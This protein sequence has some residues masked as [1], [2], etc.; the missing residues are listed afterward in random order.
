MQ[1]IS[2][3][4]ASLIIKTVAKLIVRGPEMEPPPPPQGNLRDI[5]VNVAYTIQR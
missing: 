2:S 1:Y 5:V 3:V 4:N